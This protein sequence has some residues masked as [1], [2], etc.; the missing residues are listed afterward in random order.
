MSSF[1]DINRARLVALITMNVRRKGI[2]YSNKAFISFLTQLSFERQSE[3]IDRTV[4]G[5]HLIEK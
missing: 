5:S 4:S 3:Q 2:G 1:V